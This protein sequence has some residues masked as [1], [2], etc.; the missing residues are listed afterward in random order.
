MRHFLAILL[1]LGI[2]TAIIIQAIIQISSAPNS[3]LN[4]PHAEQ[5]RKEDYPGSMGASVTTIFL[6]HDK[7]S[8]VMNYYL[9]LIKQNNW[10][11]IEVPPGQNYQGI[12]FNRLTGKRLDDQRPDSCLKRV[13]FE[14]SPKYYYLERIDSTI[15]NTG[16]TQVSIF[17]PVGP[18]RDGYIY[19]R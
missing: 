13:E 5:I 7:P 17:D 9:D 1:A 10:E 14:Y 6:T 19:Q 12:C 4:Y 11:Y 15:T 8:E 18:P 3:I 2:I 16:M